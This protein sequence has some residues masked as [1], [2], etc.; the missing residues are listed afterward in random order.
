MLST[1]VIKH[2]FLLY[3][4][5]FISILKHSYLLFFLFLSVFISGSC[6]YSAASKAFL[7]SL[8]NKDGYN[9]VKLTQYLNQHLAMY[10]CS[11]YGPTFGHH[12]I[13]ISN[14]ALDNSA[15]YTNCGYTYSAPTGYSV[16]N[17]GFFTGGQYFSPTDIEVFYEIGN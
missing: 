16:G 2:A 9:P 8:Y 6:S 5:F 7:F 3:M 15:S 13:Y 14:N 17:C 4:P 12:S 11:V 10:R 1:S